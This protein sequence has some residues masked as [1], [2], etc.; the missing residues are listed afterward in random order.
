M[1]KVIGELFDAC[2][3]V[4]AIE[5]ACVGAYLRIKELSLTRRTYLKQY[6]AGADAGLVSRCERILR[7]YGE[8]LGIEVLIDLFE[9]LVACETRKKN[10]VAYTP[11]AVKKM[12]LA[13]VLGKDKTPTVFDPSVDAPLSF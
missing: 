12:M 9:L 8:N 7:G 13:R 5:R 2:Q 10:G 1:K 3:D 11:L 4:A 6:L